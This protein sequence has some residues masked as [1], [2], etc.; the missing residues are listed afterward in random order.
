MAIFETLMGFMKAMGPSQIAMVLLSVGVILMLLI[1]IA[2]R[3]GSNKE[4][5]QAR[6]TQRTAP[7]FEPLL[8]LPDKNPS[9]DE[10]IEPAVNPITQMQHETEIK[11]SAAFETKPMVQ[12]VVSTVLSGEVPQD[13]IL[14]RHYDALHNEAAVSN[15]SS[16]VKKTLADHSRQPIVPMVVYSPEDSVLKRHFS[17][18]LRTEIQ[19]GMWP[20]PSDSVLRRHYD[21]H[22]RYELE[23]RFES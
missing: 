1:F 18:K 15:E 5:S 20:R 12:S 7:T 19:D 4:K 2:I 11:P 6:E 23:K 16:R 22:V 8:P 9:K 21:S 14:R 10:L 13:S 17:H 3:R